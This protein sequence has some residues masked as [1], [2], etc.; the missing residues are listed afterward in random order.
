[1]AGSS[2]FS[3][4]YIKHRSK[5][6]ASS[7]MLTVAWMIFVFIGAAYTNPTLF[8]FTVS[9]T[10]KGSGE[11]NAL[12]TPTVQTVD[13][14]NRN[15]NPAQSNV[16]GDEISSQ[17]SVPDPLDLMKTANLPRGFDPA[18]VDSEDDNI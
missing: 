11:A 3:R 12:T 14:S 4:R 16:E 1:M 17:D 5:R 10:T 18:P 9:T 2:S 7:S 13:P 15:P 8:S 6:G